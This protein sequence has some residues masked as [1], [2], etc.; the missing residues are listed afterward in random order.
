VVFDR[1]RENQT[2][3][4]SSPFEQVVNH[5]IVQTLDRSINT[6]LTVLMTLFAL[7]LFGGYTTLHFVIILLVGMASGAYSSIFNAA[8][9]LVVWENHEWTRWFTRKKRI[10]PAKS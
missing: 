2:K 10:A 9:I 4:R 1:I 6:T 8:A 7:A 5:S 3:Y